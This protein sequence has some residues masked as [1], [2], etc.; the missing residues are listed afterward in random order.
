VSQFVCDGPTADLCAVEF[1]SVQA[2]G[3]GSGEAVGA[4]RLAG[5][6]FLEE[7]QNRLRPGFG[8]IA[9]GVAGRPEMFLFFRTSQKVSGKQNIEATAGK[10][11]LFCGQSGADQMFAEGVEHMADEG[12][13]MAVDELLVFFKATEYPQEL[14]AAP[15][16]SS[17]IATHALHKDW[18][19][20]EKKFLFC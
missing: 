14:S 10:A 6:A 16:F 2:Q 19:R 3:F 15:V 7:I 18:R 12:R 11:E 9:A 1:E 17:G 8:V 20:G 5:E 13:S 4:R